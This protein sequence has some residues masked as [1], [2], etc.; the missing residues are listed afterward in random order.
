MKLL[1]QTPP[2]RCAV[3]MFQREFALRLAAK[4]G[5]ALY[6]R[7]S[8]FVQ[9]LAKVDHVMKVSKNNFR[10]PPQVESS[11]VRVEPLWPRPQINLDEYDGLLRIIFNRPNKTISAGF[12]TDTVLNM[13]EQNYKTEC[14]LKNKDVPMDDFSIKTAVTELLEKSG[15]AEQRA[16]KMDVSDFLS[17]LNTFNE[18]GYHF[19]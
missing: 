19:N 4:P 15:F 5:D 3:L 13:L 9:L 10:P 8:A 14:A 17:L 16:S 1:K 6:C 2:F 12:K 7:L 11:V 18:A